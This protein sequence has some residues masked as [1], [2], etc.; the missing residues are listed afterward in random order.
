MS[1]YSFL[2]N[3]LNKQSYSIPKND[4]ASI[5]YFFISEILLGRNGYKILTNNL[6]SDSKEIIYDNLNF[7]NN[8]FVN[9]VNSEHT[10]LSFLLFSLTTTGLKAG[11][12]GNIDYGLTAGRN[13]NSINDNMNLLEN[14]V[15]YKNG[16]EFYSI[17]LKEYLDEN[18]KNKT[19]K[20]FFSE[21]A[22]SLL[23]SFPIELLNVTDKSSINIEEFNWWL[24]DVKIERPNVEKVIEYFL[25]NFNSKN[26]SK[27]LP[28]SNTDNKLNLIKE[29]QEKTYDAKI[30][31]N[32]FPVNLIGNW[33]SE[34]INGTLHFSKE[35]VSFWGGPFSEKFTTKIADNVIELYFYS[36]DG[37][38]SFNDATNNDDIKKLK[39]KKLVG[40]CY[41]K[42]NILVLES[43]GDDCGQ[44]PKGTFSLKKR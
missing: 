38:N 37:T 44:L 25:K 32:Q 43:F 31:N 13:N 21:K 30:E 3:G 40:K 42:N 8:Y 14:I 39:C 5:E 9:D 19:T 7:L 16:K 6:S 28:L 20:N 17:E 12:S 15:Y 41:F 4:I 22:K 29:S 23:S 33:G 27:E 24:S 1:D 18:D 35:E 34:N 26:E 11:Y 36:I 10:K 2:P